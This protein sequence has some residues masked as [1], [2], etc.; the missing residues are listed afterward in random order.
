MFQFLHFKFCLHQYWTNDEED[1]KSICTSQS[2]EPIYSTFQ[3]VTYRTKQEH[4]ITEQLLRPLLKTSN[5]FNTQKTLRSHSRS[6]S[7]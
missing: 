5:H 7:L 1:F 4:L 3:D 2:K 6:L